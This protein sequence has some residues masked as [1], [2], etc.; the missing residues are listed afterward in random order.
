MPPLADDARSAA[1]SLSALRDWAEREKKYAMTEEL[2]NWPAPEMLALLDVVEIV[3]RRRGRFFTT[4]R[5]E[6]EIKLDA[7]LD[8]FDA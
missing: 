4:N 3:K 6:E 8:R 1:Y 5:S 7:L 2:N